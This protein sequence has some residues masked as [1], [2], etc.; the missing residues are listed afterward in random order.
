MTDHT[1]TLCPHGCGGSVSTSDVRCRSCRRDL[2]RSEL[3]LVGACWQW[4]G[5]PDHRMRCRKAVGHGGAHCEH[6]L[7]GEMCG[8]IVCGKDDGH[9]GPHSWN[10]ATLFDTIDAER[11]RAEAA[12]ARARCWKAA[13]KSLFRRLRAELVDVRAE[14]DR[15]TLSLRNVRALASRMRALAVRG[16]SARLHVTVENCD[17]LLR[18][19]AEAG[20]TAGIL[21]AACTHIADSDTPGDNLSSEPCATCGRYY[22]DEHG[23]RVVISLSTLRDL[24]RR[25]GELP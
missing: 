12:E 25:C 23:N 8:A 6:D 11:T 22:V 9:Q 16:E 1:V 2:N 15:L 5:D 19:C 17:H 18:Y 14:N 13:A 7:C 24:L 3:P 4:F 21:R 10:P 20:V